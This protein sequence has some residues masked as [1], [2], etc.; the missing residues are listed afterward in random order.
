M[1]PYKQLINYDRPLEDGERPEKVGDCARTV[2]AC[3][4]DMQPAEVPHFFEDGCTGEA[5]YQRVRKWLKNYGL[6]MVTVPFTGD[7]VSLSQLLHSIGHHNPDAYYMLTGQSRVSGG[8]VVICRGNRIVH[9]PSVGLSG[10][11]GPEKESGYY[12]VDFLV[13]LHPG[14][15][16]AQH[17]PFYRPENR[18]DK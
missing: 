7:G 9:D 3:L 13:P 8:H 1:T 4:L 14:R 18:R 6:G 15:I 17:H 12:W 5:Y 10:I 11:I 16:A 2:I